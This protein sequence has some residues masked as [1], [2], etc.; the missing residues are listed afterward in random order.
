LEQL[1]SR[2]RLA[3][4]AA[5]R[6]ERLLT[7]IESDGAAP[8]AVTAPEEAVDAHL[9]DSLSGLAVEALADARSVVDIGSGAGFPGLVLASAMP[10]ARFDLVES[11]R[12]KC[13]FMERAAAKL[14]LANV[15]VACV[16]AEDWA[17]GE[18]A[19]AYSAATARAVGRLATLLEYAAPML[20]IGGVLVTWKGR[21]DSE[22]EAEGAR[23]ADLLGMKVEAVVR[24]EPF[25]YSRNRHLHVFRKAEPCPPGHP[26]RPGMARKRPLGAAS[27]RKAPT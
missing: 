1:R 24:V 9:A 17:A 21:R 18:G 26:R 22:E 3:P 7:V 13:A 6:L 2:W 5:G 25:P 8:T 15:R 20:E 10:E 14:A 12:R 16:R 27:G 19:E 23:A 11:V 4:E